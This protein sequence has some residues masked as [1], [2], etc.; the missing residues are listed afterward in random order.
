M[1]AGDTKH[2][3]NPAGADG[4]LQPLLQVFRTQGALVEE[5]LHE[6]IFALGDHLH[7]LVAGSPGGLGHLGGNLPFCSL[8]VTVILVGERLHPQ[9]IHHAA[10]AAFFSDRQLER[11]GSAAK[12]VADGFQRPLEA[13][14]LPI[15]LVDHQ[16]PGLA[17]LLSK[18]PHFFRLHFHPCHPVHHHQR[19]IGGDQTAFGVIQKDV[20]TGRVQQIDLDLLP[21]QVGQL[22]R[23]AHPAL[24]FFF[25]EISHRVAVVHTAQP[26]HD[27]GRVEQ[28]GDQ[29]GLAGIPVADHAN[30]ADIF[31]AV[32]LQGRCSLGREGEAPPR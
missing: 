30:V 13:G 4:F 23:D 9:Q 28:P 11:N 1:I 12:Y 3:I 10:E 27:T 6:R 20:V 25:V 18:A 2:G 16:Q 31:A 7:Q 26:G 22:G 29:R 24:D 21:F 5:L 14:P 17:V 32:H 15:H 8:A 19:G